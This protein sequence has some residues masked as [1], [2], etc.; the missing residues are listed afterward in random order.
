MKSYDGFG[1]EARGAADRC[2]QVIRLGER[3]CEAGAELENSVHV[4]FCAI[5]IILLLV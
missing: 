1:Q 5:T 2:E 4:Y 3:D